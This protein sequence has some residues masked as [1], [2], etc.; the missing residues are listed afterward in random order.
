MKWLVV[1]ILLAPRL[2]SAHAFSPSLWTLKETK[3]GQFEARFK[4]SPEEV[5]GV[6]PLAVGCSGTSGALDCPDGLG[7]V[8]LPL[9]ARSELVISVHWLDG[10]ELTSVWTPG[11]PTLVLAQPRL[12]VSRVPW[13]Y[14]ALGFFHILG[15]IDHLLFVLGL[16]LLVRGRS[17][18]GVLSSFTVGHSLTLALAAM[19][20]VRLPAPP[21]EALVALS[22]VLVA[23][24]IR[25]PSDGLVRRRPYLVA[26]SFGLLHGLG[27]AGALGS[28]GLPHG[29]VATALAAF[30]VGVEVG[31][32]VFVGVLLGLGGIWQRLGPDRWR[33]APAFVV[34]A[35]GAMLFL[36]R[37]L[38]FGT[39]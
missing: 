13:R 12:A 24:E 10:S 21:I 14:G 36:D 34:G 18:V 9:A 25:R 8:R 30:N 4:A 6:V 38:A 19:G 26:L 29:Q 32:L 17:L 31:Q 33:A 7:E 35:V 27:F 23:V 15:G 2:A 22:L 5:E 20:V 37:L 39:P 28:L 11:G 16:T 1:L 3:S